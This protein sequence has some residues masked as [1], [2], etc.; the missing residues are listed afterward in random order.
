MIQQVTFDFDSTLSR[1]DVQ[2]YAMEL[3][4]RGV[5]VWVV[6]SRYDN[7]HLHK[8]EGRL[9][10]KHWDNS[11]LW[12]VVDKVGIP[13]WK[14]CFTNMEWKSEFLLGTNVIWHL[15]DDH[16]ELSHIR[17]YAGKTL[18]IQVVAGGWK[19]KCERLLNKKQ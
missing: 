13:R 12:A 16:Q 3:L 7:L 9:E 8:Y 6:T 1:S 2:E 11:D 5:D 15:D 4:A 10:E 14:V 18:G 19:R 17:K